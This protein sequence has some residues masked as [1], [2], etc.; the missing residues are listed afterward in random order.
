[1]KLGLLVPDH[2]R[3]YKLTAAICDRIRVVASVGGVCDL[4]SSIAVFAAVTRA[5]GYNLTLVIQIC[6][7]LAVVDQV[8]RAPEPCRKA[9]TSLGLGWTVAGSDVYCVIAV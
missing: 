7:V 4:A 9:Q 1:M 5:V 3:E 6:D 8:W 2:G